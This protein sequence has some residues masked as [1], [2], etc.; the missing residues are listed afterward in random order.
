MRE[1]VRKGVPSS[2]LP[3]WHWQQQARPRLSV[4]TAADQPLSLRIS[5]SAS[6]AGLELQQ[7]DSDDT[8]LVMNYLQDTCRASWKKKAG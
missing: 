8:T 5:E 1:A 6:V 4:P 3:T 2:P 7:L